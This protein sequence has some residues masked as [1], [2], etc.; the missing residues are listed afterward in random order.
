MKGYIVNYSKTYRSGALT[1]K[2][3][4]RHFWF[5]S[6]RAADGVAR[7]RNQMDDHDEL[8]RFIYEGFTV[9]A[10]EELPFNCVTED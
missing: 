1:N 2:T 8:G 5:K 4:H 3:Y 6:W 10:V 9:T 7:A